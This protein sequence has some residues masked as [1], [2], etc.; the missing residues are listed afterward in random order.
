MQGYLSFIE[1][2][3]N[4]WLYGYSWNTFVSLEALHA[5][6]CRT[7]ARVQRLY[8]VFGLL[9]RFCLKNGRIGPQIHLRV[10]EHM[11]SLIA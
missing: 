2:W 11:S 3:L 5:A 1:V 9:D 10:C 7:W 4:L 6:V 8:Y